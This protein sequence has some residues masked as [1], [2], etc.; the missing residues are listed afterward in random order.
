METVSLFAEAL[1]VIGL[2]IIPGGMALGFL[3]MTLCKLWKERK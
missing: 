2:V 3:G 1:V